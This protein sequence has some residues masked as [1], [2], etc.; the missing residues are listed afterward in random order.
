[1]TFV[2]PDEERYAPDLVRALKESGAPIPQDLQ[3]R[4]VPRMVWVKEFNRVFESQLCVVLKYLYSWLG[5][6][7]LGVGRM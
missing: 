1:M 3:V 2:S 7:G 4:A 5:N 6:W